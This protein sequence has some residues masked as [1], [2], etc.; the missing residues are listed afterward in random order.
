MNVSKWWIVPVAIAVSPCALL[1][2]GDAREAVGLALI[3]RFSCRRVHGFAEAETSPP[4]DLAPVV[5]R[6][7]A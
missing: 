1:E 6:I 5:E 4:M 2:R 3:G 7:D